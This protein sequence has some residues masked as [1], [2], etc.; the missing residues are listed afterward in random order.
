MCDYG[1]HFQHL[2][3]DWN[4]MLGLLTSCW[5][6][7]SDVAL[8]TWYGFRM[9]FWNNDNIAMSLQTLAVTL[10]LQLWRFWCCVLGAGTGR[11]GRERSSLTGPKVHLSTWRW[12]YTHTRWTSQI[13]IR[14]IWGDWGVP[15]ESLPSLA[16]LNWCESL[17]SCANRTNRH[18]YIVKGLNVW[19]IRLDDAVL[20]GWR[21]CDSCYCRQTNGHTT[22]HWSASVG[23]T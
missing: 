20:S 9:L 2:Q 16:G 1:S 6:I 4:V 17:C 5:V 7:V 11:G 3:A 12:T 18:S 23:T 10:E 22:M 21:S 13:P 19:Q 14:H 15:Q 8:D